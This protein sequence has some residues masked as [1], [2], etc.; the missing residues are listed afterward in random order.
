MAEVGT[1]RALEW[2]GSNRDTRFALFL[3]YIDIHQWPA[4]V[5]R[6]LY[7]VPFDRLTAGQRAQIRRAYDARCAAL[8]HSIDQLLSRL[9]ETG[10]LDNTIVILTADHGEAIAEYGRIEGHGQGVEENILRVPLAIFGPG[11]EP[12]EI[13][14]RVSL[15]SITPTIL[16]YAGVRAHPELAT[17]TLRP[18]I[19]GVRQRD[20]NFIS[21]FVL[22]GDDQSALY[23]GS[24]KYV[25]AGG[26]D[27]LF[28]LHRDPTATRNVAHAHPDVTTRLRREFRKREIDMLQ[29]L[30][31]QQDPG[32]TLSPETIEALRSL[33]YIS[34]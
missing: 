5:P 13:P 30:Q 20:R 34:Q 21:E 16:D 19:N 3:H 1:P 33:G 9:K 23:S 24:W 11:I 26:N 10:V 15:R 31:A 17:R 6:E 14:T 4:D 27:L 32:I 7:A 25:N 18:M 22:Y 2:I 8:D 29:R 28:D 12:V